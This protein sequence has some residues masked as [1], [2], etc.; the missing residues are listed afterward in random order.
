M[1]H[2]DH[3]G[4]GGDGCGGG[5]NIVA[6]DDGDDDDGDD[7]DGDDD[8]DDDESGGPKGSLVN[9]NVK[10]ADNAALTKASASA[11]SRSSAASVA[12]APAQPSAP[13][14]VF[15]EVTIDKKAAGRIVIQL[16]G[17][18]PKTAANFKALCTGEKGFGFKGRLARLI[19]RSCNRVADAALQ[20]I[21]PHH[22]R[23]HVAGIV[24][25]NF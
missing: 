21:P 8:D 15:F 9:P 25:C 6:D 12:V 22:P 13:E 1:A 19:L 3:E 18:V 11:S 23:L 4:S 24:F 2:S 7:D 20:H 14:V 16:Y 5:G 10:A 17:D